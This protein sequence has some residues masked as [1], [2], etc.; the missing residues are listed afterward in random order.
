MKARQQEALD[1]NETQGL[2]DFTVS[3]C[4]QIDCMIGRLDQSQL[5]MVSNTII[6]F[7][8]PFLLITDTTCT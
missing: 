7:F 8:L 1:M 5:E 6:H 3:V 2:T 4:T